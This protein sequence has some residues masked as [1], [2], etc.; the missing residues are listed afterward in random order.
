MKKQYIT[1]AIETVNIELANMIA[2]SVRIYNGNSGGDDG[3]GGYN[4]ENS[5]S[6]ERRG[7]WGDLWRG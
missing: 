4:P 7:S 2:G 5:L 1:P 6:N 3:E